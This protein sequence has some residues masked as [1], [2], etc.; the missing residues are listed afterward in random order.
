MAFQLPVKS[1]RYPPSDS[2][3][4]SDA[5][6]GVR[7]VHQANVAQARAFV[8]RFGADAPASAVALAGLGGKNSFARRVGLVRHRLYKHG[9]L[10]NMS[11]LAFA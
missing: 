2:E 8:E 10:R 11:L 6:A 4:R 1:R 9:F 5:L 7:I 3:S